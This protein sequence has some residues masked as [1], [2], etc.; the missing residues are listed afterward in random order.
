[1]NKEVVRELIQDEFNEKTLT[2]ELHKIL[3]TTNRQKMFSSYFELEKKL[4]GAGASKNVA[5]L[6]VK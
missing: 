4:G 5:N 3:D 1:M 6:I 2:K